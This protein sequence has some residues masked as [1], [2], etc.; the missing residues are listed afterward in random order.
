MGRVNTFI[1]PQGKGQKMGHYQPRVASNR[2]GRNVGGRVKQT[3]LP[4]VVAAN[5]PN[6]GGKDNGA[7]PA[8]STVNLRC[9]ADLDNLGKQLFACP[10]V[11]KAD[12]ITLVRVKVY[13]TM[14]ASRA[15]P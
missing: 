14:T 5:F 10:R 12:R 15:Q 9:P 1:F 6:T 2:F 8:A 11:N 7:S 13:H 4:H 3:A